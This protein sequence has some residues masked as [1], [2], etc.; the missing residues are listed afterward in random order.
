MERPEFQLS[1][2]EVLALEERKKNNLK[3]VIGA[4]CC[5][6]EKAQETHYSEEELLKFGKSCF[7]KG[8]SKS[9]NDDANCY[10]AFREEIGSLFEQ[11]KTK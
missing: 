11:F 1:K 5:G 2:L 10:T 4:F 3:S 6:Y 8:F 7:Y 9:E